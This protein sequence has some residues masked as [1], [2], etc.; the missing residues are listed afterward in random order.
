MTAPAI[1]HQ[2]QANDMLVIKAIYESCP[3]MTLPQAK[4]IWTSIKDTRMPTVR[5]SYS[6][7]VI[8]AVRTV[9]PDLDKPSTRAGRSQFTRFDD[10]YDAVTTSVSAENLDMAA[11]R[12]SVNFYSDA[13]IATRRQSDLYEKELDAA[14]RKNAALEAE[15][16]LR[17]DELEE[18]RAALDKQTALANA[19]TRDLS[20]V[21]DALTRTQND[22]DRSYELAESYKNL[23]ITDQANAVKA[24]E[25]VRT[26]LDRINTLTNALTNAM[27]LVSELTSTTI[28]TIRNDASEINDDLFGG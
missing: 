20:S 18:C 16:Q 10:V 1:R 25:H 24:E 17:G 9:Y 21:R 26:L 3:G 19:L 22:R 27:A 2:I 15:I 12:N 28:R 6:A 11:L 13:A 14:A 8:Q 5:V 23:R 4:Q 7:S